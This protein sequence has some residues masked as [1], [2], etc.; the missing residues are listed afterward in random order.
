MLISLIKKIFHKA[1]Y[2]LI[3]HEN[4]IVEAGLIKINGANQWVYKRSENKNNPVLL[5]LHPGPGFVATGLTNGYQKILEKYFTVVHWHM[6]GAGK[7]YSKAISKTKISIDLLVDD[8]LFLAQQLMKIHQKK[9]VYIMGHSFGSLIALKAV[10]KRPAFFRHFISIAQMTDVEEMEKRSF[11]FVLEA[12]TKAKD[13]KALKSLNRISRST[14][15][16]TIDGIKKKQDLIHK[17]GGNAPGFKS[18]LE[19]L[20]LLIVNPV[21]HSL[22]DVIKCFKGLSYSG[23]QLFREACEVNFFREITKVD[24]PVLMVFGENDQISNSDLIR[25]Y[26]DR[27]EAPKKELI[28]IKGGGHFP[29][30]SQP[31]NFQNTVISKLGIN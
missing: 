8:T 10:K 18:I 2:P 21:E 17:F 12:A 4:S 29:F 19:L 22:S 25:S 13:G 30:L 26:Y 1:S 20:L 27:L 23:S 9:N 3:E 16:L 11:D 15:N 6:R 14:D 28:E 24:T 7:S 5:F 31:E